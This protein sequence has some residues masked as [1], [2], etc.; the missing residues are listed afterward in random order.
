MP[1]SAESVQQVPAPAFTAAVGSG[2]HIVLPHWY[3]F[4]RRVHTDGSIDVQAKPSSTAH[5]SQPS[6]SRKLPSS[7][8]SS[9]SR[10]PSPQPTGRVFTSR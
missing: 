8:S 6:P 1:Q 9:P 3:G 10:W 7:H 2:S 4:G 5:S